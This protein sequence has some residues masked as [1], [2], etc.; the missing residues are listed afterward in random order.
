MY[1]WGFWLLGFLNPFTGVGFLNLCTCAG[2]DFDFLVF[3]NGVLVLVVTLTP[4]FSFCVLV[5]L[6]TLTSGFFQAVYKCLW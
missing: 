3:L 4:W 5:L 1:L 6:M 2:G